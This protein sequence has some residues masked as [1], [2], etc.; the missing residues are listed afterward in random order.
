[1][2]FGHRNT[3]FR[4]FAKLKVGDTITLEV[5]GADPGS[6]TVYTYSIISMAV[7]TPD[8]PRIFRAIRGT[9]C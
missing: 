5:P 1:M 8:D 3:V 2:I 6:K 7:V 4:G 9:K